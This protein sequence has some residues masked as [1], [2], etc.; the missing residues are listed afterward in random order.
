MAIEIF[1]RDEE[2][3]IEPPPRVG[4]EAVNPS[5]PGCGYDL[6]GTLERTPQRCP[7]CGRE[8]T[9]EELALQH[10][11]RCGDG[12]P[13]M[14]LAAAIGP[15][16]TI[17]FLL[18]IGLLFGPPV[19]WLTWPVAALGAV[20]ATVEWAKDYYR[21]SFAC[22]RSRV[23]RFGYIA[24]RTGLLVLLNTL[25]VGV[26]GVLLLAAIVSCERGGAG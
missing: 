15:G 17:G 5:C 3:D 20:F 18:F 24:A 11:A 7:E 22:A 19:L 25:L 14:L 21:R 12:R 10:L 2:D 8:W 16:L 6:A 4:E 13:S 9:L 23:N 1:E 26:G